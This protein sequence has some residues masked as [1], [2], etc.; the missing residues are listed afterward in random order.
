MTNYEVVIAGLF[1]EWP[2]N[3]GGN[4]NYMTEAC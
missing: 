3:A 2:P 1:V 4:I